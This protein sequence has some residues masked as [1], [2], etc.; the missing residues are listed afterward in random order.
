MQVI[1]TQ[2]KKMKRLTLSSLF[3]PDF[4]DHLLIY[5]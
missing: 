2:G 3:S 5:Q 1:L 4:S